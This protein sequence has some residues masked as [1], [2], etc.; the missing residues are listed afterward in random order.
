[1]LWLPYPL[2]C[3]LL[4]IFLRTTHIASNCARWYSVPLPL[5]QVGL[6]KVFPSLLHRSSPSSWAST[7]IARLRLSLAQS[8]GSNVDLLL[9]VFPAR[10]TFLLR[11]VPVFHVAFHFS[12]LST[13]FCK[14]FDSHFVATSFGLLLF[15]ADAPCHA[16]HSGG[17]VAS[18]RSS[19]IPLVPQGPFSLDDYLGHHVVRALSSRARTQH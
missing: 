3:F 1:M 8:S 5:V 7:G 13:F 10:L 19:G 15:Y 2:W 14:L 6:C 4:I 11:T 16:T 9:L 18:A 12:S 17:P